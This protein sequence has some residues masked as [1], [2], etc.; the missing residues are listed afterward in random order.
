LNYWI[1]VG[2][3][4]GTSL[5]KSVSS[6]TFEW[7]DQRPGGGYHEH[8]LGPIGDANYNTGYNV[9]I[10]FAGSN[11]WAINAGGYNST[12]TNTN[13]SSGETLFA[14]G[15]TTDASGAKMC[16]H[17]YSLGYY[18][19]NGNPHDGWQNGGNIAV[20]WN[21]NTDPPSANWIIQPKEE[22]TYD[23]ESSSC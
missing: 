15:E 10:T 5:Q 9:S 13:F 11:S 12:S 16:Y 21:H 23:N 3:T 2:P 17:D 4:L 18:G 19:I 6:P 22:R 8:T 14:G 7:V 20:I 1:E